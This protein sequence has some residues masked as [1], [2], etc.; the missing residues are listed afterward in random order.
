MEKTLPELLS[1]SE[2][3]LR[4]IA[5]ALALA[6]FHADACRMLGMASI[7]THDV[8]EKLA[9]AEAVLRVAQ[10]DAVDECPI[11]PEAPKLTLLAS[12]S[13]DKKK[14]ARTK[15]PARRPAYLPVSG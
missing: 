13:E 1:R 7:V 2:A 12:T 9:A 14:R 11:I 8:R 4:T 6:G 3:D 10:S 5:K 15:R